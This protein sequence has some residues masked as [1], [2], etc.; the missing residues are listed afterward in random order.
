MR[1]KSKKKMLEKLF[2]C[3]QG[4]WYCPTPFIKN[5]YTLVPTRWD[6]LQMSHQ[7]STGLSE[8]TSSFC[9]AINLLCVLGKQLPLSDP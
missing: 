8:P 9:L 6:V 7:R 3:D 2:R 1:I 5:S 4:H